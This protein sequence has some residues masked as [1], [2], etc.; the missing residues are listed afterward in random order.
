[1]MYGDTDPPCFESLKEIYFFRPAVK[2]SV[3]LHYDGLVTQSGEYLWGSTGW[4]N[5]NR[6][7]VEC[8][9]WLDC[10]G[11]LYHVGLK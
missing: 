3:Q 6:D 4:R 5:W 9:T 2:G 7:E 11:K 1:M 8:F 10:G